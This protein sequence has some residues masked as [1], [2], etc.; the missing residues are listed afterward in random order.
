MYTLPEYVISQFYGCQLDEPPDFS[1]DHQKNIMCLYFT[2][3]YVN[4]KCV[5][6]F[7]E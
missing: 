6:S 1:G 4:V 5:F 7:W 2:T 3:D